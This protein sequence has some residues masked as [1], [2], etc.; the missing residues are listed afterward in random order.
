MSYYDELKKSMD[1]MGKNPKS[2]FLGQAVMDKGT[3]M[4]NT[5][6]GVDKKKLIEL[7]VAEEMQMGMT[8]GLIMQGFVP[9]SIY[10]RMN[11][12]LLAINQL[13]NHLD[14]INE[15]TDNHYKSKAIIRT[16]VG[17]KK[18]LDPK[19]QHV[20]DFSYSIKR[21]A[22]NIK[23]VCLKEKNQI[24][25]EYKKAIDRKDNVSTILIEYADYYNLK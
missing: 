20:G 16:A 12:L 22:K 4:T 25:R 2:I 19:S 8:N 17:S 24:F 10:P 13:V 6:K 14:K 9:I 18:P 3:A 1:Y 23:V 5:F 21:M 7:P 11:F 15:M